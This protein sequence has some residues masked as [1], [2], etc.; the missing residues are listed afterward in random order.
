MVDQRE[1]RRLLGLHARA[2]VLQ[3]RRAGRTHTVRNEIVAT[4]CIESESFGVQVSVFCL[5][6]VTMYN[7]KASFSPQNTQYG[8]KL[9]SGFLLQ[10]DV[11]TLT[12]Y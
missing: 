11:E 7:L 2:D 8:P 1:V 3:A 5:F 12:L 9:Q 4:V 6:S 10:L